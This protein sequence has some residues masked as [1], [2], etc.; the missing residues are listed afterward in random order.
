MLVL[1]V[2]YFEGEE[3]YSPSM[4]LIHVVLRA[5]TA[6]KI[7]ALRTNKEEQRFFSRGCIFTRLLDR[8]EIEQ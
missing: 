8:P 5:N 7:E 2:L 4:F 6:S 3:E 1:Y